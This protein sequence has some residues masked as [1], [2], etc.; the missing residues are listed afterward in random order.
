MTATVVH[1]NK[2]PR[3]W[4]SD[5]RYV[6][7]GRTGRGLDGSL[8]NPHAIG[9]CVRCGYGHMRN[10]AI[11]LFEQEA[12]LR[13]ERDPVFRQRVLALDGKFLV[14]FCAPQRCHADW[15][16]NKLKAQP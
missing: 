15:Y 8:G 6:Y 3:D 13:F 10:A 16:V 14:C 4:R 12:E 9:L 5:P 2:V 7:V 1:I 11:D